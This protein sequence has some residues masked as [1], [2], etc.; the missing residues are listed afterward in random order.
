MQ[1]L[2]STM[3]EDFRSKTR[4]VKQLESRLRD[5]D[6]HIEMLEAVVHELQR[7]FVVQVENAERTGTPLKNTV[8]AVA[9]GE[10]VGTGKAIAAKVGAYVVTTEA[11]AGSEKEM[12]NII[13]RGPTQGS[14]PGISAS[15]EADDEAPWVES[16]S[17]QIDESLAPAPVPAQ[18]RAQARAP[19]PVR[20]RAPALTSVAAGVPAELPTPTPTPTTTT[21]KAADSAGVS[22]AVPASDSRKK[23]HMSLARPDST[24]HV[25]GLAGGNDNDVSS[26]SSDDSFDPLVA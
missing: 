16:G 5:R 3:F 15:E 23:A 25:A 20:A 12:R 17:D 9:S 18:A 1:S 13:R 6:A 8:S 21:K 11:A 14:A 2:M 7:Q 22:S 24:E 10:G 26:L 19:A 4:R